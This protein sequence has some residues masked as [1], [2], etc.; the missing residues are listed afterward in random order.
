[1]PV[2]LIPFHSQSS[3]GGINAVSRILFAKSSNVSDY[4]RL[5]IAIWLYMT[6]PDGFDL[7]IYFP[8]ETF[9]YLRLL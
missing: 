7:S 5:V 3:F 6:V 4:W 9:N 1:M 8:M 2:K